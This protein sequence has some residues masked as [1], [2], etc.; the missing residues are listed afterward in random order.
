MSKHSAT[1]DGPGKDPEKPESIQS[2]GGKARAKK[3]SP[4]Q[5]K[6]AASEAAKA[7]WITKSKHQGNFIND[8]GID[9]DCYVLDDTNK[10][11]VISQRG[12]ARALGLPTGGAELPRFLA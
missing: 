5:R 9:V 6:Q 4:E 3:L 10:T 1:P 12:M 8:F 7:R 2:K 11:A